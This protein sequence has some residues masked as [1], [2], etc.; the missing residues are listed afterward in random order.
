MADIIPVTTHGDGSSFLPEDETVKKTKP[1]LKK[2]TSF[3]VPPEEAP[4]HE[5]GDAPKKK[6]KL[7][8]LNYKAIEDASWRYG[9]VCL[10]PKF[11]QYLNNPKGYLFFLCVF[12]FAQGFTVNGMVYVVLS[13]LERRFNLPSV[14]SGFISSTYD[15]A[16]MCVVV[17]VTYFGE[18]GHKPFILA[19]GAFLFSIGSAT[20]TLPHFLSDP[21]NYESVEFELCKANRTNP[22]ICNTEEADSLSRFYGVFIAAQILHGVGSSPIYTLGLTYIDENLPPK[23]A[24]IYTGILQAT[25]VFGPALGFVFGGFFLDMYTDFHLDVGDIDITP[26]SPLWVGA[27]WLGFLVSASIAL[28][29]VLPML[30]FPKHLPA[31]HIAQLNKHR[32]SRAGSEVSFKPAPGVAKVAH[33]PLS[34]LALAK[35]PTYCLIV[36]AAVCETFIMAFVS[37]FGPKYVESLFTMTA[38]NAALL[39]GVIVVP[40]GVTGNL[41]GGWVIKHFNMTIPMMLKAILCS[42]IFGFFA[43]AMFI[44]SCPNPHFAGVNVGYTNSSNIEGNLTSICNLDCNCEDA[45][46]PVCGSDN[47][48]YYSSCHAGC[49]MLLDPAD[50]GTKQ[51]GDCAC[52]V[53]GTDWGGSAVAGLCREKCD[54]MVPYFIVLFAILTSTF[55]IAVPSLTCVLRCVDYSQRS[56]ALGV[57]SVLSKGLGYVP[58]PIIFGALIDKACLLWEREC[59]SDETKNCWQYDNKQLAYTM[60]G[61]AAVLR[62]LSICFYTGALCT[63]KPAEDGLEGVESETTAL[64]KKDTENG[65]VITHSSSYKA[66]E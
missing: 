12:V 44:A 14:R 17:F 32:E 26:D 24:A 1:K 62:F 51:Y 27:W 2:Q 50:D 7:T 63:Y 33:L 4:G 28:I 23:S 58:G 47:I 36:A 43:M 19:I 48:M 31:Y 42:I 29:V 8:E 11:L 25:A 55:F 60:I 57:Q 53:N 61:M 18:R 56:F 59:D 3:S 39:I 5:N 34:F 15:L 20:F 66:I 54:I 40:A 10:R 37:A 21:Y 6:P 65:S 35:N 9:W 30:G 46:D 49:T 16:V 45:Y 38:G 64:F 41:L 22:E 52:I 13:T